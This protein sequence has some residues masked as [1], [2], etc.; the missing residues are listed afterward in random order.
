M[1]LGADAA[2]TLRET[3]GTADPSELAAAA[4][5]TVRRSD[6]NGVGDLRLYG[7]Y[8]ESVITLYDRQISHL[9][10]ELGVAES[11]ARD[12]VLAHELGHHVVRADRNE[13]PDAPDAGDRPTW[14]RLLASWVGSDGDGREHEERAAHGFAL[15]LLGDRLPAA[16]RT[17]L[18]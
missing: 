15:E 11:L 14:R 9:A 3:H 4:D 7:T 2:R 13:S 12:L 6:W 5:V 17:K 16:A 10:D 1:S 18:R 8:A